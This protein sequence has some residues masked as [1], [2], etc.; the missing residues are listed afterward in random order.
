MLR[1]GSK[2]K[3]VDIFCYFICKIIPVCCGFSSQAPHCHAAYDFSEEIREKERER[4][5]ERER[6]GEGERENFITI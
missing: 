4:E 5:R 3:S 2:Q 6:E 1:Y